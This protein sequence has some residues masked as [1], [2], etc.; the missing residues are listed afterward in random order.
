MNE[1]LLQKDDNLFNLE[2]SLAT[3]EVEA[4]HA[5]SQAESTA[6]VKVRQLEEDIRRITK[7]ADMARLDVFR[8]KQV[9]QQ[10]MQQLQKQV[11]PT[12]TQLAQHRNET[13]VLK[14]NSEHNLVERVIVAEP[15]KNGAKVPGERNPDV[16]ET[17]NRKD[18]LSPSQHFMDSNRHASHQS[19][20]KS[21]IVSR[22][23]YVTST[24]LKLSMPYQE[25]EKYRLNWNNRVAFIRSI[26]LHM[27]TVPSS[28]IPMELSGTCMTTGT[29]VREMIR[30]L[31]IEIEIYSSNILQ[32]EKGN[33][34]LESPSSPPKERKRLRE[35]IAAFDDDR[36][37]SEPPALEPVRTLLRLFTDLLSVSA[38]ARMELRSCISSSYYP[39]DTSFDSYK[40]Q[41]STSYSIRNPSRVLSRI[42]GLPQTESLR[43]SLSSLIIDINEGAYG[44][45]VSS[46]P[47]SS[48]VNEECNVLCAQFMLYLSDVIVGHLPCSISFKVEA[49]SFLLTTMIDVGPETSK[50]LLTD[51]MINYRALLFVCFPYL[52]NHRIKR[53]GLYCDRDVISILESDIGDHLDFARRRHNLLSVSSGKGAAS[54]TGEGVAAAYTFDNFT[55][56]HSNK[57]GVISL[58][59]SAMQLLHALILSSRSARDTIIH[60]VIHDG[61]KYRPDVTHARRIMAAVLDELQTFILPQL[62]ASSSHSGEDPWPMT[63]IPALKLCFY[64]IRLICLLCEFDSGFTLVRTRMKITHQSDESTKDSVSAMTIIVD[65]LLVSGR[66]LIRNSDESSPISRRLPTEWSVLLGETVV[67]FKLV[68]GHVQR[69]R[70]LIDDGQ[71]SKRELVTLNAILSEADRKESFCSICRMLLLAKSSLNRGIIIEEDSYQRIISLLDEIVFDEEDEEITG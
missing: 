27:A 20:P 14:Q 6:I 51:E 62:S 21:H 67:F 71:K 39:N 34:D 17:E 56:E 9:H 13:S 43:N 69:L 45:D 50:S 37:D 36:N 70:K 23:S 60:N 55:G 7:E 12:E 66:I 35:H 19:S 29:L 61:S 64:S 46:S 10:Q 4:K 8:A 15:V 63:L 68:L 54:S 16:A 30:T 40:T 65:I 5:I 53:K 48:S 2:S 52:R 24:L 26:I 25:N 3:V 31:V 59:I 28:N 1:L 42:R 57:I 47:H 58:K 33:C 18:I 44:C 38:E 32:C 41:S 22:S 49:V 11:I